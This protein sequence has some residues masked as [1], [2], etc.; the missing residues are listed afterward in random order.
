MSITSG[1]SSYRARESLRYDDN[2]D[3]DNSSA[4]SWSILL[5]LFC[6]AVITGGMNTATK[7]KTT[8]DDDDAVPTTRSTAPSP[9]TSVSKLDYNITRRHRKMPPLPS[10]ISSIISHFVRISSESFVML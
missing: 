4:E 7:T 6:K 5:Y 2:D 9:S 1:T 8:L 10:T 3:G